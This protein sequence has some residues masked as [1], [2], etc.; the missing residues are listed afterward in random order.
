MGEQWNKGEGGGGGQREE[1]EEGEE[2]KERKE[3]GRRRLGEIVCNN[4]FTFNQSEK[5]R[6]TTGGRREEG[7]RRGRRGREETEGSVS[8]HTMLPR[9]VLNRT[10]HT[11]HPAH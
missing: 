5:Q 9:T 8:Y 6:G 2:R 1:R 3:R 7:G 4:Q 10:I 11:S